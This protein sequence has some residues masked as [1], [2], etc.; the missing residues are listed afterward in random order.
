[1]WHNGGNMLLLSAAAEMTVTPLDFMTGFC[2]FTHLENKTA[3][4][5]FYCSAWFISE[6][7][8]SSWPNPSWIMLLLTWCWSS[9]FCVCVWG[10]S[11]CRGEWISVWMCESFSTWQSKQSH[12]YRPTTLSN[13]NTQMY[14]GRGCAIRQQDYTYWPLLEVLY[15]VNLKYAAKALAAKVKALLVWVL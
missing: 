12:W 4:F 8:S 11:A 2:I 5:F 13:P 14:Y 3:D 6:N 15:L 10:V 9:D 7:V 1:M